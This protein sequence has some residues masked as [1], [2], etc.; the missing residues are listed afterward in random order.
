MLAELEKAG[1]LTPTSL[2]LSSVEMPFERCE[3]LAAMLGR[4]RDV[5]SWAIADL[6]VYSEGLFGEDY[7]HIAEATGRSRHTLSN[8]SW[9]GS[10]VKPKT[11]RADLSFSHHGEV[12]KLEPN[13]QRHWLK[14]AAEGGWSVETLRLELRENGHGPAER[15]TWS[16]HER[17]VRE[18]KLGRLLGEVVEA[19]ADPNPEMLT[20][21]LPEIAERARELLA[22]VPDVGKIQRTC[23]SCGATFEEV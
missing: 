19:V 1:A 23:P 7:V 8:Y 2:D 10:H 22:E 21:R 3:A 15:P 18:Q 11:R 13:D 16:D 6:L 14:L 5:T 12:A 4:M 9:V 20:L 17:A